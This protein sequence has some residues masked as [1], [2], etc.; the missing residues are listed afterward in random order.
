MAMPEAERALREQLVALLRGGMAH[1][2]FD[3]AVADFPTDRINERPPHVPYTP[4]HL[5]EH[6]RLTQRDIIEFSRDPAYC[7]RRWPEEY[8]PDPAAATDAAGWAGTIAA[9]RADL[10]EV[11]ALALDPATDL[12]ARIPWGD[13]Q[14][15]LREILLVADHNSHHLGEFAIL[16]SAS[17]DGDLARVAPGVAGTYTARTR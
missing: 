12:H 11:C 13:G 10:E 7:E 3:E 17:G 9:F 1:M 5:L 8:W 14:T 4:W 6:L 15:I 16:H 2:T